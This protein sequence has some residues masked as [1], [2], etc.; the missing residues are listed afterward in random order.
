MQIIYLSTNKQGQPNYI[1]EEEAKQ[2]EKIVIGIE[3]EIENSKTSYLITQPQEVF[4]R[5]ETLENSIL[6][7]NAKVALPQWLLEKIEQHQV[8]AINIKHPNYA[9]AINTKKPKQWKVNMVGLGDVGSTLLIGLKLLGRGTITEI[10]I[11]SQRKSMNQRLEMELNQVGEAFTEENFPFIKII[12]KK[13]SMNCDMFVFCASAG[14][15]PV[16]SESKDVR[17]VQLEDNAKIIKEY[18]E[19]ARQDNFQGI[20]AVVSDPVDLLCQKV[21]SYSNANAQGQYDGLGLRA[22][23]IR[24]Y[25]LG[26]MN[27]RANYHAKKMKIMNYHEEGRAYGPHGQG[28]VIA[29]SIKAYDP[30]QSLE[31]TQKTIESNLAVRELG[32]KPYIAPA[33]SS[34]SISLLATMKGEYH[35]SCVYIDGAFLG[36]KNRETD[37]GIQIEKLDIPETLFSRIKTTHEQLKNSKK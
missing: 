36:I 20:F 29:D 35:Y 24:G 30:V 37:L 13:D 1:T 4:Y 31:L 3:R 2:Q 15:P 22:E 18:A 34:G 16:G 23:Q 25:G 12:E 14:V 7:D 19:M 5:E 32:F 8:M 33:L 28:L 21:Y 26:V 17:M 10:G 9:K 11:C 6:K 27:T